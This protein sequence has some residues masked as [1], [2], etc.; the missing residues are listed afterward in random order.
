M[1][2]LKKSEAKI[3]MVQGTGS[4]VG[5]S[6]VAAALCRIFLQDGYRVCPFKS[7]NMALNSYVTG[8]GGEMGRA[9]VMQAEAAGLKP[10]VYMNPI[11]IKPVADRNAQI[12]FMGKVVKNMTAVEYD[13]KKTKYLNKISDILFEIK[14]KFDIIV[15]EGAGSPAEINLIEND[16]VNMKIADL[17]HCPVMLV[18]DIDRGGIFA[19]FYGTVKILPD[20]YQSFFRCLLINKFRGDRSLLDPG[21]DWIEKKLNM[22]VIGVIPYYRNIFIDEEDSV[23]FEK[24]IFKTGNYREKSSVNTIKICVI[25]LPHI[26]NFTDFNALEQQKDVDLFYITKKEELTEINPHIIII[27]GSKSTVSDLLYIRK[28]GLENRIKKHYFDGSII[29]GICGGYQMLGEKISDPCRTENTS[30]N[31]I[32]GISLIEMETV[33]KKNKY[34]KQVF[35]RI[36]SELLKKA[37][38]NLN[39]IIKENNKNLQKGYEIHMGTSKIRKKTAGYVPWDEQSRYEISGPLLE[40]S[41]E[42]GGTYRDGY[43]YLDKIRKMAVIGTY[44]H[45]VFDNHVFR[46]FILE[47][48]RQN[49][50]IKS[51][52]ADSDDNDFYRFK[53]AQY[54]KLADLFRENID[55]KKLYYII[56][57][58][59]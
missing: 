23:N 59:I 39:K 52:N 49:F 19:S 18:G 25:Y 34:T 30:T 55:L 26:S 13:A 41:K 3:I 7:Q 8:S 32:E 31:S 51:N 15:I 35:F 46:N 45:G 48:A 6:V 17:A 4:H 42:T 10:E 50:G 1:Q 16:I 43:F 36:N 2:S 38:G 20:R 24:Q 29:I 33:F 22:P 58:G 53:D 40:V 12:I 44:V 57:K 37:D 54:D 28:S 14:R 47:T 9:Q 5:K 11:L 21:I 27:P 56:Q